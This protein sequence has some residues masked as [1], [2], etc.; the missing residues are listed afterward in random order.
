M[1]TSAYESSPAA[2][3]RGEDLI[4]IY[5]TMLLIRRFDE[6]VLELRESGEIEGVV[7]SYVGEEAVAA[8]ICSGLRATDGL[9]STHR[10]HGHCIAK[11]ADPRRMMAELFGRADGYCKGKGG[12]MHI[13]DFNIGM[14]GANGIVAAGL[15]IAMGAALAAEIEGTDAVTVCMFG[16]G[17]VGAGP[18]HECLNIASLWRLP[19]IF[20]C[21]NN[22]WAVSSQPEDVLAA[23]ISELGKS[24]G[25]KA[26]VVDGNDVLEVMRVGGEAI[27]QVRSGNGP[28][29][30]EA[31]TFRMKSHASRGDYRPETRDPRLLQ[32][33]ELR[34]PIVRLARYLIDDGRVPAPVIANLR[35]S[36]EE[37]IEMAVAFGRSSPLPDVSSAL[38]DVFAP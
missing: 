26:I 16:D 11:G 15:P 25:L 3:S 27:D 6:R 28:V 33:W 7:H 36:V 22:G 37:E 17:A 5:R 38:T 4:S 31:Q 2:A 23:P 30:I 29:L 8:G 34:D 12:S 20:V 35:S 10:G 14:L 18:F 19:I 24:Y 21:E 9:T 1:K 32:E 13:A